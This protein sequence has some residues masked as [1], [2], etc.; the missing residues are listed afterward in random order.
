MPSR[1]KRYF[2]SGIFCV[3][4]SIWPDE[5]CRR[6]IRRIVLP[7]VFPMCRKMTVG[8]LRI[9]LRHDSLWLRVGRSGDASRHPRSSRRSDRPISTALPRRARR[10]AMMTAP[11]PVRV[12]CVAATGQSGSTLLARMLG[13]VPGYQAVGEV[14]RVWD[15]GVD[16]HMNCSCGE[17]FD[18]LRVL[19]RG[20]RA[21]VRRM[22]HRRRR[23]NGATS[24]R[25]ADGRHA[26]PASRWRCRSCSTRI[27]GRA[28]ATRSAGTPT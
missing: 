25:A 12:L 3:R 16:E 22:A 8:S 26:L 13:E 1:R 18:I 9:C 7:A 14:G 20:R 27:S 11:E 19:G 23:R 2:G 24:W 21:S 6:R 17:P 5:N 28:S 4:S 15:K 10:G